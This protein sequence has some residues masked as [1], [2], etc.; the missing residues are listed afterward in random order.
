M[1]L[2]VNF[3]LDESIFYEILKLPIPYVIYIQFKQFIYQLNAH[4]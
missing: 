2:F 4:S 3:V 1:L